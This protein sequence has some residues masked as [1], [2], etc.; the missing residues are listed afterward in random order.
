MAVGG[1]PTLMDVNFSG[2]RKKLE[3]QNQQKFELD[4]QMFLRDSAYNVSPN[5]SWNGAELDFKAGNKPMSKEGL[6]NIYK[7]RAESMEPP[8]KIDPLR[9]EQEM[10]PMYTQMAHSK[11]QEQLGT[12]QM[13]G[14]PDKAWDDLYRD[15]PEYS[16]ALRGAI[17]NE[18][19]PAKVQAMSSYIPEAQPE[20]LTEAFME[21]PLTFGGAGALAYG[22][23][24]GLHGML[25]KS[26]WKHAGAVSGTLGAA[27]PMLAASF[28]NPL[29]KMLGA[30]DYEAQMA[31]ALGAGG[32]A[33]YYGISGTSGLLRDRLAGGL[34]NTNDMAALKQRAQALGIN[35]VDGKSTG[36]ART[37]I[38]S[39]KLKTNIASKVQGQNYRTSSALIKKA[40]IKPKGGSAGLGKAGLSRL[41]GYGKL[42]MGV[43]TALQL[44]NLAKGLWDDSDDAPWAE[45]R[46]ITQVNPYREVK[47]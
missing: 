41:G 11:F 47:R 32:A 12:L 21:N 3:A 25:K 19:D 27:A 4:F 18:T 39:S 24:K 34:I 20:G 5:L 17:Q 29:A 38:D 44:Y 16:A 15:N 1:V 40:N 6:W 35:T 46:E 28:A 37:K 26:N 30:T 10:W 23:G 31:G 45:E 13:M 14:L 36:D 7:R 9:F 8:A 42:G 43:L 2:Q 22:A 33:G